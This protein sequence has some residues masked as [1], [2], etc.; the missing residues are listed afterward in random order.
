[1]L[2]SV[3]GE[4]P[5]MWTTSGRVGANVDA[6]RPIPGLP[7]SEVK[8]RSGGQITVPAFRWQGAHGVGEHAP[9]RLPTHAGVGHLVNSRS[10]NAPV[11]SDR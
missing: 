10:Q 2:C 9:L 1:M 8:A 5:T 6:A 3:N 4:V 11:A 7:K